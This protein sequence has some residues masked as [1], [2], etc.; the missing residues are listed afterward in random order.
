[1]SDT[2]L[3]ISKRMET[4]LN[5]V[6][7]LSKNRLVPNSAENCSI[8]KSEEGMLDNLLMN[9]HNLPSDTPVLDKTFS[10]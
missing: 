7:E 10:I 3:N 8:S 6:L 4:L 9:T 5:M 2:L 1:M